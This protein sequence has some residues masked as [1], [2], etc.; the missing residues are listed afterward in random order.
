MTSLLAPFVDRELLTSP[1]PWLDMVYGI[2]DELTLQGHLQASARKK[3]LQQL[4]QIFRQ[5]PNIVAQNSSNLDDQGRSGNAEEPRNS[6]FGN[7]DEDTTLGTPNFGYNFFDDAI[8][9]NTFTADQLMTVAD[10]LDLDGIEEMT[11]GSFN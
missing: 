7:P 1:Q 6:L 5:S 2:L 10:G 11:T 3:E 4:Q 8:W 9:P